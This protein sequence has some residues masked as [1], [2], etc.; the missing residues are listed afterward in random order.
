MK[1]AIVIFSLLAVITCAVFAES[2]AAAIRKIDETERSAGIEAAKQEIAKGVIHYEIVGQP[3]RIDQ[4]IKS[5]ALSEYGITVDFSGC[6]G[7]PRVDFS[8]GY[9]ETVINHLKNKYGFDPV[10]RIQETI[11][12]RTSR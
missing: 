1:Q 9:R 12:S 10:M 3:M 8:N 11:M 4:E 6:T 7:S 5:R 2:P